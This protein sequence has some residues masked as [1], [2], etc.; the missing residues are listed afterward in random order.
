MQ[1]TL[2]CKTS[3]GQSHISGLLFFCFK[4]TNYEK[5]SLMI[6]KKDL[7]DT[8]V[9]CLS[10]HVICTDILFARVNCKSKFRL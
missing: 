1:Q 8:A 7:R 9:I 2:T 6:Y 5:S 3:E 10:F 4:E